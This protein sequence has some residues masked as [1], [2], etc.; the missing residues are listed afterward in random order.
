MTRPCNLELRGL[1]GSEPCG[2]CGRP[3]RDHR[4][5][6]EY[7][8][9]GAETYRVET[10]VIVPRDP[11]GRAEWWAP[12][13]RLTPMGHVFASVDEARNAIDEWRALYDKPI[14]REHLRIVSSTGAVVETFEPAKVEPKPTVIHECCEACTERD[15]F[16]PGPVPKGFSVESTR[17]ALD[18]TQCFSVRASALI[19]DDGVD[20]SFRW[21]FAAQG[22]GFWTAEHDRLLASKDLSPLAR[23][24]L[25]AWVAQSEAKPVSTGY[26]VEYRYEGSSFVGQWTHDDELAEDASIGRALSHAATSRIEN[27]LLAFRV[28]APDGTVV[29]E[30]ERADCAPDRPTVT[31]SQEAYDA[32]IAGAKREGWSRAAIKL[33]DGHRFV[34][35][36][37]YL[38]RTNPD[39]W[40]TPPNP[41]T[42]IA[43]ALGCDADEVACLDSI[44]SLRRELE[45]A[46]DASSMERQRRKD[47][48]STRDA[49][50]DLASN[51]G[52]QVSRLTA[53]LAKA[54][55]A[56]PARGFPEALRERIAEWCE[57]FRDLRR[58]GDA[59]V[60]SQILV[61]EIQAWL[62]SQPADET[63][64]L[65]ARVRELE[66]ERDAA[67]GRG[68]EEAFRVVCEE[69]PCI[70]R[71][72]DESGDW[73]DAIGR[74]ETYLAIRALADRGAK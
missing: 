34:S 46:E 59:P 8:E 60:E 40:P 43:S 23:R 18:R 39:A 38:A 19:G 21:A 28:V 22:W 63:E 48:E 47:A 51:R 62:A 27:P 53:E 45:C 24:I 25:E 15:A 33:R 11:A 41:L 12:S 72:R 35:A 50:V 66:T 44:D 67:Y 42:A 7:V 56:A 17:I 29:D 20:E 10:A 2:A 30:A 58:S 9:P 55:E 3:A 4:G 65:R 26:R 73:T 54:L 61:Q 74:R 57:W 6:R 32:A 68:I 14:G 64:A 69:A 37:D 1:S 49:A 13:S 36:S 5:H 52:E 31:M 70:A 16:D 71:V